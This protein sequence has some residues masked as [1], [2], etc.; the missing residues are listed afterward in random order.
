MR[1]RLRSVSMRLALGVG[2]GIVAFVQ[3]AFGHPMVEGGMKTGF[4][5]AS[6]FNIVA[7]AA[8]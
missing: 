5:C 2:L 4:V 7:S 6:G 1:I 3:L 8:C